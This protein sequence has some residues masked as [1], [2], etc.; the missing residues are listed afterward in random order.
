MALV[1]ISKA[2]AINR[3]RKAK[4]T[5]G[6]Y[7]NPDSEDCETCALGAVFAPEGDHK[8]INKLCD[9][10]AGNDDWNGYDAEMGERLG[11]EGRPLRGIVHAF[12]SAFRNADAPRAESLEVA[13]AA[14]ISYAERWFPEIIK[15]EA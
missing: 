10:A 1:R 6:I 12:E 14:A 3:I 11:K 15:V 8:W 9:A 13:R 2:E 4:L 5:W 7:I